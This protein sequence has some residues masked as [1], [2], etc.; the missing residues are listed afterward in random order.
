MKVYDK[1]R[2]GI[3]TS[4]GKESKFIYYICLLEEVRSLRRSKSSKQNIKVEVC[5]HGKEKQAK[6]NR[7]SVSFLHGVKSCALDTIVR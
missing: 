7:K 2:I 1:K 5:A 6:W 4:T 3:I